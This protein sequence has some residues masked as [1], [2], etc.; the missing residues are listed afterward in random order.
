MDVADLSSIIF[1]QTCYSFTNLGDESFIALLLALLVASSTTLL[2]GFT[3]L[4]EEETR[5]DVQRTVSAQ[6]VYAKAYGLA[7]NTP[8]EVSE[9]GDD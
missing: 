4:E 2:G 1:S 9:E 3:D 5:S 6:P 7:G 8:A